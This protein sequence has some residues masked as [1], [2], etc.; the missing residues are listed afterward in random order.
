MIK[1]RNFSKDMKLGNVGEN[2]LREMLM[3]KR[4]DGEIQFFIDE[5]TNSASQR[6]DIDFSVVLNDGRKVTYECKTDRYGKESRNISYELTSNFFAGCLARSN[7]DYVYYVFVDEDDKIVEIYLIELQKWR[8]W[9]GQY[10]AFIVHF[11]SD[12]KSPFKLFWSKD[13]GVLQFLCNIDAMV[14]DEVAEKL[15]D[16]NK[17]KKD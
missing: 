7:A 10:A 3:K 5:T 2:S 14:E 9:M 15:F 17:T 11:Q 6:D 13:I 16:I 8:K 12:E 4:S 1:P